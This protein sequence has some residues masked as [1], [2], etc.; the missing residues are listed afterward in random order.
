MQ[1]R[2]QRCFRSK[3]TELK[4]K[5]KSAKD[6]LQ[7]LKDQGEVDADE[8]LNDTNDVQMVAYAWS[9][10]TIA[11]YRKSRDRDVARARQIVLADA[12]LEPLIESG[13]DEDTPSESGDA[14]AK[15]RMKKRKV[16]R[17][18]AEAANGESIPAPKKQMHHEMD[19]IENFFLGRSSK[20]DDAQP[21]TIVSSN[22][23]DI[24]K[25]F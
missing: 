9:S 15:V 18:P 10:N 22:A 14:S 11:N 19:D 7:L 20:C 4:K 16:N 1:L 3:T 12:R 2:C 21:D 13:S 17:G 23:S 5:Y 8:E 24:F 6:E 25:G